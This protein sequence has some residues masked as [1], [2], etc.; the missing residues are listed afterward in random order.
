[1]V[2]RVLKLSLDIEDM[3]KELFDNLMEELMAILGLLGK[4]VQ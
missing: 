4:K 2:Y 1:M 3:S